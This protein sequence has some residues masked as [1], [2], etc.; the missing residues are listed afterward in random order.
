MK[1]LNIFFLIISIILLSSCDLGSMRNKLS[2]NESILNF[3][4]LILKTKS[5]VSNLYNVSVEIF[6]L[7][8]SEE[9]KNHWKIEDQQKEQFFQNIN[10]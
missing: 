7:K 9:H 5:K 3:Y 8:F 6:L 2:K 4:S 1:K 10:F